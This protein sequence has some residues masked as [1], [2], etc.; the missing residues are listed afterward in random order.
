MKAKKDKAK[1]K[2]KPKKGKRSELM[3]RVAGLEDRVT[4]LEQAQTAPIPPVA[5]SLPEG[6]LPPQGVV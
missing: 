6:G 1:A 3:T 5:H 4:R 2:A